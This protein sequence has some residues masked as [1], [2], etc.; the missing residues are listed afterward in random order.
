MSLEWAENYVSLIE[1][2][3]SFSS[4]AINRKIAGHEKSEGGNHTLPSVLVGMGAQADLRML[5]LFCHWSL[6]SY[7]PQGFS[8]TQICIPLSTNMSW[9]TDTSEQTG[10]QHQETKI[11]KISDK[12]INKTQLKAKAILKQIW[13]KK[14][15]YHLL[16]AQ[17][18]WLKNFLSRFLQFI[19]LWR[20]A[21]CVF[22]RLWIFILIK[23]TV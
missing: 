14:C 1:N 15:N 8:E 13:K 19:C 20:E 16:L 4:I 7:P 11:I 5:C 21:I 9:L 2:I 18:Y 22:L 23:K 12:I 3:C 6:T 10:L 17:S